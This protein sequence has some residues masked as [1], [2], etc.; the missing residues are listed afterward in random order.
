MER[1][2]KINAVNSLSDSCTGVGVV[3]G[4]SAMVLIMEGP[5]VRNGEVNQRIKLLEILQEVRIIYKTRNQLIFIVLSLTFTPLV[6]GGEPV[7]NELRALRLSEA[8]RAMSWTRCGSMLVA[9]IVLTRLQRF[10]LTRGEPQLFAVYQVSEPLRRQIRRIS[11]ASRTDEIYEV[12][13][14]AQKYRSW[15]SLFGS[16]TPWNNNQGHGIYFFRSI[17]QFGKTGLTVSSEQLLNVPGEFKK[18]LC[19]AIPQG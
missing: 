10:G 7:P 8:E 13:W 11:G 19:K 12:R 18:P 14:Y 6:R 15:Y 9:N 17:V 5:H 16:W 1:C 4:F 2:G 3:A